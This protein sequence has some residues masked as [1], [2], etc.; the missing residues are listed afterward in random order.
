MRTASGRLVVSGHSPVVARTAI[1]GAGIA[2]MSAAR[3]LAE[4]RH[5][6]TVFEKSRGAGGRAA[7]RRRDGFEF[8]HGAQ[9]FTARSRAFRD[10]VNAWRQEGVV[11]EWRGRIVSLG[12]G[13]ERST[14]AWYVG[15]PGMSSVARCLGRGLKMHCGHRVD[16]AV[17]EAAG[18]KLIFEGGRTAG[19][20][21]NL[22]LTMPAPQAVELLSEACPP[23]AERCKAVRML[24]C[25]AIMLALR[26]RLDVGFD[27]ALVET[28]GPIRWLARNSSKPRR[29][30]GET[31]VVHA[32]SDWTI[33]HLERPREEV[34]ERMTR[35]VEEI[36][37]SR[38][39]PSLSMAH[40]WRYALVAR[41][42]GESCLIDEELGLGVAGDWCLG[43]RIECAFLSGVEAAARLS[44][45]RPSDP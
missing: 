21:D 17:R 13:R 15:V 32:R 44:T 39:R 12:A 7:R 26:D 9:Y 38:V 43:P 40:R 45:R 35:S 23:F 27:A 4:E 8:D 3:K 5:D 31:W 14:S 10:H 24:P 19:P 11:E 37:G 34:L 16:V 41:P 18:W 1:V 25:W 22:L 42:L 30:A 33:E 36:V 28:A 29:P 6:V 2:G 20:F